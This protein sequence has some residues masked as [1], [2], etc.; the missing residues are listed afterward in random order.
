MGSYQSN[1]AAFMAEQRQMLDERL[2]QAA[3]VMATY[4]RNQ[5]AQDYPPASAQGAYPARRTGELQAGISVEKPAELKRDIVSSAPHTIWLEIKAPENGGRPFLLRTLMA[6]KD[7]VAT[8]VLQ[9]NDYRSG[10]QPFSRSFAP[11][12]EPVPN[13]GFGSQP[14]LFGGG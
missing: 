3:E 4:M 8:I 14:L 5:L 10:V 9:S 12:F 1:S 7:Q 6:T 13:A 2:G 11:G